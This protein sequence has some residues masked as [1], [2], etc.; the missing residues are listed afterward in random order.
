MNKYFQVHSLFSAQVFHGALN[1]AEQF[2]DNR[3][4]VEHYRRLFGPNG[5]GLKLGKPVISLPVTRVLIS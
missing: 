2:P 3:K 1:S 4:M 5:A